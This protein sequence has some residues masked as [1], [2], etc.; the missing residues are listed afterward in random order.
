MIEIL[1]VD[2]EPLMLQGLGR[3][4]KSKEDVWSMEFVESGC[5]ALD[6]MENKKY[7]I[8]VSDMRMPEM[9]GTE[10]LNEVRVRF[11][12]TVR[13]ILSGYSEKDMILRSVGTAHQYLS[14]PF[15]AEGLEETIARALS[16]KQ[17]L[18]DTNLQKLI[19]QIEGLPK[20]PKLYQELMDEIGKEDPESHVIASIIN[21]DIGMTAKIL[22]IMNSAFFGLR[23]S[24]SDVHDAVKML[25]T[26][27]I[28]SLALSVGVFDQIQV[29][30]ELY[31]DLRDIWSHSMAVGLTAKAISSH[32]GCTMG[33]EAFS[34]GFLHDVG[35]LVM[36][37]NMS[38]LYKEVVVL[39]ETGQMSRLEAEIEVYGTTHNAIGAYLL[40]LWG[41][42]RNMVEAV[43]FYCEP[44]SYS[45]RS[46]RPLTALH[47][48]H[49]LCENKSD[50]LEEITP[51][52]DLVYL[53]K[54]RADVGIPAWY[55]MYHEL[56]GE[57][58]R[59]DKGQG[60]TDDSGSEARV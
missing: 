16:L 3:M 44:G 14:K 22:Q 38:R 48:A 7:D 18:T 35:T 29:P 1:F 53:R 56:N 28:K 21:R 37:S 6:R 23:R 2:D 20:L 33:D 13:I 49:I 25:G 17:V 43:A 59:W 31:G 54:I 51:K 58:R 5:E 27:T 50:T 4:L 32:E 41:L 8:V 57:E 12:D 24:V 34:V 52:F 19:S 47:V 42:P 46:F 40:G 45:Y 30:R 11:P 9:D 39:V 26:D 60:S 36:I 55:E 10:L 15:S